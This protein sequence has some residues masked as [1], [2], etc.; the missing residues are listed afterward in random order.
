MTKVNNSNNFGKR[1]ASQV[2]SILKSNGF[3]CKAENLGDGRTFDVK[4]ESNIKNRYAL[5]KAGFILCS[6]K[7][8]DNYITIKTH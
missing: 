7:E 8:G 6:G 5:K 1:T 2:S 4:I 3:D